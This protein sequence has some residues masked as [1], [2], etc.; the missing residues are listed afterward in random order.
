MYYVVFLLMAI[1]AIA[2]ASRNFAFG[3]I[4][5]LV[6]ELSRSTLDRLV[7]GFHFRLDGPVSWT[8]Q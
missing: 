7:A 5:Q 3:D 4:M 6:V 8:W 1:F 2:I